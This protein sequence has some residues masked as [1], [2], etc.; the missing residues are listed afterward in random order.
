ML[1]LCDFA[2]RKRDRNGDYFNDDCYS[3]YSVDDDDDNVD[4]DDDEVPETMNIK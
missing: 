4:H 1:Y 2:H 3:D